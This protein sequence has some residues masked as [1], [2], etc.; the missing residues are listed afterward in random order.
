M[1][2]LNCQKKVLKMANFGLA[3]IPAPVNDYDLQFF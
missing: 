3:S 1:V 2:D